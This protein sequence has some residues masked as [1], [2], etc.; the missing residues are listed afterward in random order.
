M[1][2]R[3]WFG[4]TRSEDADDYVEYLERTGV[5]AHRSTPGNRGSLV[6]RRAR[7][8]TVEFL[9]LSL[10]ESEDAIRGFAG[11][12]IEQAVYF[13]EDERF[14]IERRDLIDHYEIAGGSIAPD[15]PDSRMA[16]AGGP[17]E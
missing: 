3:L 2:A 6:L 4:S 9:V 12:S 7:G 8:D 10:W 14:L 17:G 5:S 13:P 15:A 1:I 16:R 11:D